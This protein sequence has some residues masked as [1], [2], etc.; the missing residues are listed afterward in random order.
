[1]SKSVLL[2][3][4]LPVGLLVGCTANEP[5]Y[6]EI[7]YPVMA[8]GQA[9][10]EYGEA[11]WGGSVERTVMLAND[12]GMPMGIGA[13]EIG[14]IET[15]SSSFSVSWDAC[16][17]ECPEATADEGAEAKSIDVDTGST[18]GDD[19]GSTGGDDTGGGSTCGGGD[20]IALF[21]LDPGCQIPLT[22][23]YTPVVQGEAYDALV[24]TSVGLPLTE[25]DEKNNVDLPAY[26][27]DPIRTQQVVY[28]HGESLYEQGAVVVQ[29]RSYDFG[30]VHPDGADNEAPAR[31]EIA[32]VGDG[33]VTILGAE[34]SST[35]DEAYRDPDHPLLKHFED[36]RV[37]EGGDTTLAEVWFRPVDTN[38]A[39]CEL[40]IYTDDPANP[41]VDVTLTGN[42]GTDPDNV[43]P[44]VAV[45]SPE[46]GYRYNT[47]RPLTL[48]LNIFDINQPASSL[49]CT[50]KSAVIQ[51]AT[52]ARCE[53]DD[54]SGHVYV[55][56]PA[57]NL[58]AGTDTLLV[59]VVDGSGTQSYASVSVVI[60]ADYPADDDDGDGYG[61]N[62]DP[63]DCDD[64]NALTYP[65]AAEVFDLQ[66]NDCDSDVDE[67]TDGYDDDGDGVSEADGD[68]NDASEDVFPGAPETGDSLDNDC[69]G[70][71]DESTGLY[72]DDGDGFAEVNQ[73]CDDTNP[74]IN[75]SA[76]EIC[77]GFDNDCDGFFDSADGCAQTEAPAVL[78]GDVIRMEQSACLEGEVVTMD[79]LV[80]DADDDT[81]TYTWSTDDPTVPSFDNPAAPIVNF[82]CP[83][84]AGDT[85]NSGR[86]ENIYVVIGDDDGTDWAFG[87]IAV[88]DE[89]TELYEPY[90][91]VIPPDP[92][93]S[94][95]STAGGAPAG[96]LLALG[97]LFGLVRRRRE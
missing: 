64:T 35:C 92:N 49:V 95:C 25:E 16:A 29:P 46:N 51:V 65:E 70:T 48:E 37:L 43:P 71:V 12:G 83:E 22:V 97:A 63:A 55:E 74:D 57:E 69:D 6:E 80:H 4:T 60:N 82:T 38:A 14:D 39:R 24:V 9:S 18:G 52:V 93:A 72:D 88:W 44:M 10:L 68:C 47:I 13:I 21:V 11:D 75:P 94:A 20:E 77:D 50:V 79:V 8:L 59:T 62:G 87:R 86:N 19:T 32:N 31:I 7:E 34:L 42:S 41:H 36:G 2:A 5:E 54:E 96:A 53:A 78:V 76:T 1:M 3:L 26:K 15:G 89:N 45:R 90:T 84:I 66:D 67:G 58:E 30:Y 56:V 73:D 27:E 81:I 91:K 17:I 40:I 28:L 33:D 85:A 61:V 23:T